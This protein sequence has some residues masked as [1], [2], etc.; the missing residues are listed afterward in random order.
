ACKSVDDCDRGDPDCRMATCENERCVYVDEP[1]GTQLP[2]ARQKPGDCV[3]IQCD[4]V[5]KSRIVGVPADIP[6][7]NEACTVDQCVGTEPRHVFLSAISCYSGPFGTEG[8]G[9]C[10]GGVQACE[11]GKATG[12]CLQERIPQPE[13]CL[14]IFDDDCD[15]SVNEEGDGCICVPGSIGKCYPSNQETLGYGQCAAGTQLCNMAGTAYD[16]CQ[17]FVD[18]QPEVCDANGSDED[19][20]GKINEEGLNCV[21]GDGFVSNGETCDDGNTMDGDACSSSCTVPMCGDAMVA[22]GEACDDGNPDNGDACTTQCKNAACGDGFLWFGTEECDDGNVVTTDACTAECKVATCGDGIVHMGLE[23]CDDGG[24]TTD[25]FSN[26]KRWR[27]ATCAEVKARIPTAQDGDYTLYVN[28]D[29]AKPW[30]AYCHTMD[31]TPLEYLTL[32][33]GPGVNYSQ[34]SAGGARP[35]TD[36]VTTYTKIRLDPGTLEVNRTDMTFATSVGLIMVNPMTMFTSVNY[37]FAGDCKGGMSKTGQANVDLTG[38]PFILQMGTRFQ[39]NSAGTLSPMAT[40]TWC[41]F[42]SNSAGS[43][44]LSSDRKRADVNGGGYCGSTTPKSLGATTCDGK[45]ILNYGP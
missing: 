9:N 24:E 8:M 42:G 11:N 10:R 32:N 39:D 40:D 44:V 2:I 34:Y 35:G 23:E 13:T 19:C 27:P 7:D 28:Q 15:G 38:T 3:E 22:G 17:G 21:C 37:A 1:E 43:L 14:N 12:P 20:D 33:T 31:S 30:L 4:G 16:G 29:P 25:C 26:C 45:L 18:P 6:D 5:G 41:T 36:V